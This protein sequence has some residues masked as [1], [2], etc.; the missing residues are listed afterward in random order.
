MSAAIWKF[1]LQIT[2]LQDIPMPGGASLL[3]VQIQRSEPML[4]ALVTAD[5]PNVLRRLR[6]VGTGH[7][8]DDVSAGQYVAT[9]QSLSGLLVFHVF[10]LG[11]VSA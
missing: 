7:P 9:F 8:C 2:D 4:W 5:A 6:I 1:P 11:T 10:D 3:S